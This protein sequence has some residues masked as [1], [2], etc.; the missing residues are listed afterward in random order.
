M[1]KLLPKMRILRFLILLLFL[2]L[3]EEPLTAQSGLLGPAFSSFVDSV[4]ATPVEQRPTLV[5]SFVAKVKPTPLVESDTVAYFLY[6]GAASSVGVPGD[7]NGWDPTDFRMSQLEGTD[8]W[9]YQAVFEPEARLDYKLALNGAEWI[10]DP[11]NPLTVAGGF[12]ANS[13]LAMP[14]YVQPAEIE[15][16]P[17]IGHGVIVDHRNFASA[18]LGDSRTVRVFLP[19]EYEMSGDRR[20]GVMLFND[21][22]EYFSIGR[23]RNVIDFLISEEL[24]A[25]IIGVFVP[26]NR[27]N[28]EYGFGLQD[29]Y[30]EFIVEELMPFVDATYRTNTDPEMRGTIG[31]SL[32]GVI[33]AQLCYRHPEQ[34]GLCALVSP[35]FQVNDRALLTEIEAGARKDVRFYVDWGTYEPTIETVAEAFV[36][37]IEARGYEYEANAWFEGHSWG[38]WRGHLSD[39]LEYLFPAGVGTNR[40]NPP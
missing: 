13:E 9:Y 32:G 33:S 19:A 8:L 25:P 22:L 31:P 29:D 35:S 14:G 4:L 30:E 38:N 28:E 24:I 17:D 15:R 21:G 27:R 7:M 26:P 39:A 5:D 23:A 1:P 2:G 40:L 37:V 3:I 10:L 18:S 20:Y 6:R 16:Y 12:G 34:F 11:L 36:S